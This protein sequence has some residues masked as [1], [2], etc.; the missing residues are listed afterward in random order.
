MCMHTAQH[1]ACMHV[2]CAVHVHARSVLRRVHAHEMPAQAASCSCTAN[3]R[4]HTTCSPAWGAREVHAHVRACRHGVLA[5]IVSGG[6]GVV[7]VYA[8]SECPAPQGKTLFSAAVPHEPHEPVVLLVPA[9][10]RTC[11]IPCPDAAV[12][13]TQAGVLRGVGTLEADAAAAS[14][15]RAEKYTAADLSRRST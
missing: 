3:A 11:A 12:V 7:R 15:W 4:R 8:V 14:G 2:H 10:W 13:Q 6:S 9:C 1:A 5:G